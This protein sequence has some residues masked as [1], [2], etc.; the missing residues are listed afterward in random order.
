MAE[1][2]VHKNMRDGTI[3]IFSGSDSY[4]IKYEQGTLNLNTPGPSRSVY[5]DRGRFADSLHGTPQVR[6]NEDQSQT[7]SFTCYLRDFSDNSYVTVAE[8]IW[9]CG[10]YLST[11][12][13]TLG[14]NAEVPTVSIEWT[15]AGVTH[16]EA[17]DHVV[18]LQF[19]HIDGAVGE[20]DPDVITINFE[21][22]DLYPTVT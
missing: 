10:Q 14:A 22:Y 15:V 9:K 21:S 20:G 4:T 8:F 6:Y 2:T 7:G 19:V 17:S 12:A 18:L 5:R 3:R 1:A 13:S 11:W 16:G